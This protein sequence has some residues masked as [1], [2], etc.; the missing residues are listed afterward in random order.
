[1]PAAQSFIQILGTF[2]LIFYNS[3]EAN[4]HLKKNGIKQIKTVKTLTNT[5][6]ILS[7]FNFIYQI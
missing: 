7:K 4:F 5:E 2:L 3:L 6:L 1:M